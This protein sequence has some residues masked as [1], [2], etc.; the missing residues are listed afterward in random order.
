MPFFS[1]EDIS[2]KLHFG[3]KSVV[4]GLGTVSTP[5]V[6]K[7]GYFVTLEAFSVGDHIIKLESSSSSNGNKVYTHIDSGTC[8]SIYG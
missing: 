1:K 5:I 2:S 8:S 7:F 4:S 6:Y 3:D